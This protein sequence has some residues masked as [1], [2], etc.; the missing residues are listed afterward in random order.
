MNFGLDFLDTKTKAT[1]GE[2]MEV[3]HP[4]TGKPTGVK[5]KYA[6]PDSDLYQEAEAAVAAEIVL[7][8]SEAM[9]EAIAGGD[10]DAIKTAFLA[11]MQEPEQR[12]ISLLARIALE[13][14]GVV[15]DTGQPV[16][17]NISNAKDFHA[18]YPVV[19]EQADKFIY[20]RRTWLLEVQENLSSG[21]VETSASDLTRQATN[22]NS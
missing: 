3:K 16:V 2:W 20:N 10:G 17:L 18:A 5:I 11:S 7:I 4:L 13:W 15:D 22:G 19:V 8:N 9:K 12:R 1:R 6:G 21:Q 14:S